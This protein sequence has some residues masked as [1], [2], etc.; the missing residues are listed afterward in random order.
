MPFPALESQRPAGEGCF[1]RFT[2]RRD[3][4]LGG[5]RI[6]CH[7]GILPYFSLNFR[8]LSI[9]RRRLTGSESL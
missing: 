8:C 5:S 6:F 4:R 3:I 7:G 2:Q 9:R 1:F